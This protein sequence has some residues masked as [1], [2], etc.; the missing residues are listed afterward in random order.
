MTKD[1]IKPSAVI[2]ILLLLAMAT[3]TLGY[4][5]C[6]QLDMNLLMEC[7][8][9]NDGLIDASDRWLVMQDYHA[10]TRTLDQVNQ[11]QY[12]YENRCPVDTPATGYVVYI[13]IGGIILIG[14]ILYM[15][16]NKPT[17]KR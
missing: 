10:G 11:T 9:D 16:Q 5:S 1:Y 2:A 8:V 6:N 12:A 7:D 3:P 13:I 14:I 17:K 4:T 15:R